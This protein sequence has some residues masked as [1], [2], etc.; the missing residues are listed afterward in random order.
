MTKFLFKGL[1]NLRNEIV[2]EF[3]YAYTEE[4]AKVIM[5]RRMAKK[6]EV[7]PVVIF[8]WLKE[9]PNSYEI[10]REKK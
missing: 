10:K 1:F 2:R 3:A 7:L 9:H 8:G 4:Q 6:Q 5:V